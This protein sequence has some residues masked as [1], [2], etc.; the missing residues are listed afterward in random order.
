MKTL[1][2]LFTFANY[3]QLL[4][5]MTVGLSLLGALGIIFQAQWVARI[6]DSVFL[7]E[8]DLDTIW[9]WIFVVICIIIFRAGF[10]FTKEIL[11]TRLAVKIKT[12]LREQLYEHIQKLG[13]VHA[14]GEKSGELVSIVV[15][16]IETLDAFFSQFL[17]Q[18]FL[19]ALIPLSIL[20]VVFPVDLLTGII[21]IFTA[22]LLPLF[23]VLIGRTAEEI[24]KKQWTAFS[25]MSAH[26]Q[27]TLQGLETLKLLNQSI[28]K[29]KEIM[30]VS[31]QYRAATMQVLRVSFLSALVLELLGTISTAI[32]AV[33]IGLRLLYGTLG[34]QEAMF[35]L[36]I[37]PEFYIPLRKLGLRF[38][39]GMNGVS[40]ATRI[41]EVLNTQSNDEGS[42][43]KQEHGHYIFPD[44]M[45][46][47]FSKVSF[48]YAHRK[49]NALEDIS[50]KI[51]SGQRI[52]LIGSNGAGKSTIFRLIMR[53]IDPDEGNIQINSRKIQDI[54][55][56]LW[57][58]N[59]AWVAQSSYLF[60]ASIK[61][62]IALGQSS[63]SEIEIR[64][65]ARMARIAEWIEKQPHGYETFIGNQGGKISAGQAQRIVLA[66]AF[67]KNAPILLLDEPAAHLDKKLEVEFINI[68]ADIDKS[69][70]VFVIAHR[71]NVLHKMD[72]VLVL[73]QGRLIKSGEPEEI[74][75][76]FLRDEKPLENWGIE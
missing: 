72:Q 12:A 39:A 66:R 22:P 64:N 74:I 29:G 26:F 15:Q 40:A 42:I 30:D 13:P 53:F 16:G 36:L 62:N 54:P 68:L 27:D 52:G 5:V 35:I 45:D 10:E 9:P 19:A 51:R 31:E 8:G 25:R 48:S 41:F 4:L 65:A 70:T 23:M 43:E 20:V 18:V 6:I 49:R 58:S 38:H 46:L 14:H 59:I 67:L 63:A 73:D 55:L 47:S 76:E 60:N 11:A 34:F 61:A 69:K 3:Q 71:L 21:F 7:R 57:R 32:V 17:P 2:R 44:V 24:T 75:Q 50:F 1:R 33:Q 28:V 56:N 37:A